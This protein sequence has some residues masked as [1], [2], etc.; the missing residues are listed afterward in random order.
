MNGT[1]FGGIIAQVLRSGAVRVHQVDLKVARAFRGEQ[2]HVVYC[3]SG[4]GVMPI[5]K[6]SPIGFI[7]YL[8]QA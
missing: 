8:F 2:Q 1:V 5:S 6:S 7:P 4:T 3:I